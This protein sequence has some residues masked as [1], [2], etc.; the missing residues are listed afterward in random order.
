MYDSSSR[1]SD[2]V[3]SCFLIKLHLFIV[4]CLPHG[5][6]SVTSKLVMQKGLANPG[7]SSFALNSFAIANEQNDVSFL[8][9]A[10]I[11]FP[12]LFS[13]KFLCNSSGEHSSGSCLSFSFFCNS[14]DEEGTARVPFCSNPYSFLVF[15][16]KLKNAGSL[17]PNSTTNLFG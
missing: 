16:S 11:D 8:S 1:D 13:S 15:S 5:H 14:S 6:T 12:C 10:E 4:E 3:L 7:C 9:E 2:G 17:G